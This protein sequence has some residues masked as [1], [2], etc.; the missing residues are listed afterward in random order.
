M[1]TTETASENKPV[2][3]IN[4]VVELSKATLRQDKEDGLSCTEQAKKYGLP[5]TQ[6][7]KALKIA[8][9]TERAKTKLKFTLKD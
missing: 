9:I 4:K 1:N 6:I 8:G 3:L 2:Q 5:V 7:R